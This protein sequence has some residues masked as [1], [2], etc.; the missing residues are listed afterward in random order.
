MRVNKLPLCFHFH[1]RMYTTDYAS[2]GH[3]AKVSPGAPEALCLHQNALQ[4]V[5]TH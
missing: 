4:Q 3:P 1:L 5:K 2:G